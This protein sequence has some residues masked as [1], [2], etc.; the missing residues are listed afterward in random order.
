MDMPNI[1]AGILTTQ[2]WLSAIPA[3]VTLWAQVKGFIPQPYATYV[4][5][6]CV[7]IYG[8]ARTVHVAVVQVEAIKAQAQP[9][10]MTVTTTAPT[11]TVTSPNA[12]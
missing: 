9:K 3:A 10:Q 6:G 12:V 1:K 2:F 5:L 7:A 8:I 11:T 4:E